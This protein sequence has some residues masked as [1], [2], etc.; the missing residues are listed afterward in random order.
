MEGGRGEEEDGTK[1][2]RERLGKEGRK[3]R[4]KR[5]WEVGRW[6]GGKERKGRGGREFCVL[7]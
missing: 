3:A 6:V 1:G 7:A 5:D 2:G 4:G